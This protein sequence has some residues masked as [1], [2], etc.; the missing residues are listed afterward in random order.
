MKSEK[1]KLLIKTFD[2]SLLNLK[3][4]PKCL[5]SSV[6]FSIK[7]YD[8]DGDKSLKKAKIVFK[9]VVSVDFE[10]NYFDN[11]IGAELFGFYEI[12]DSEKKKQMIEKVFSNRLEGYLY[13]GD[14]DYDANEQHDM[15]NWREPVDS[16]MLE[17]EKYRLFQQQT[18]GGIYYVLA[19]EYD[20]IAK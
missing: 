19:A 6:E 12:F 17:L 20:V 18:Q 1:S 3:I 5:N 2:G 14:Y 8:Y 4:N 15:L 7:Y 16:I 9:K 10:I 13:H 11:F